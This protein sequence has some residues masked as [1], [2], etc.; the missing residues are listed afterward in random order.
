MAPQANNPSPALED[1]NGWLL[2]QAGPSQLVRK[3]QL[4]TRGELSGPAPPGTASDASCPPPCTDYLPPPLSVLQ[5]VLPPKPRA[6][7]RQP[8]ALLPPPPPSSSC[9][10]LGQCPS[11][12]PR[13]PRQ[14]YFAFFKSDL[15][16]PTPGGLAGLGLPR[17]RAQQA[18]C[19]CF[20]EARPSLKM[21]NI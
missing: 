5:S 12:Q 17:A 18:F 1:V 8:R 19:D 15:Q 9:P 6:S 4:V 20:A 21:M 16:L 13:R 3:V 11:V 10:G 14:G 2:W 7:G